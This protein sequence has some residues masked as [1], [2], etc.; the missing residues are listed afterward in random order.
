MLTWPT[1][2]SKRFAPGNIC[3]LVRATCRLRQPVAPTYVPVCMT[4]STCVVRLKVFIFGNMSTETFNQ[5]EENYE[6]KKKVLDLS[7]SK[8]WI[9]LFQQHKII[10]KIEAKIFRGNKSEQH[11]AFGDMSPQATFHVAEGN[12]LLQHNYCHRYA[13]ENSAIGDRRSES[14]LTFCFNTRLQHVS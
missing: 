11:V 8:P 10:A 7:G 4:L 13:A 5:N 3:L 14:V 1:C 12:M 9:I 2:C 6:G